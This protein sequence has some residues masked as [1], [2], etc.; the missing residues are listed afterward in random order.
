MDKNNGLNQSNQKRTGAY[1]AAKLKH[2][3]FNSMH[4]AVAEELAE[5][6]ESPGDLGCAEQT[7]LRQP[8]ALTV[9]EEPNPIFSDPNR[10]G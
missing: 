6:C 8:G 5:L 9:E 10:K 4:D 2:Y 7:D 3:D 1:T